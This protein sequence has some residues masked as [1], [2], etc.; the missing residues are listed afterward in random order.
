MRNIKE[1]LSQY[2]NEALIE[3]RALGDQL[4]EEAHQA[5][6]DI[7]NERGQILP[8]RPMAPIMHVKDRKVDRGFFEKTGWLIV[9][10]GVLV[11]SKALAHTWLGIPLSLL[12]L[13]VWGI[14]KIR[15]R[16]FSKEEAKEDKDIEA[17]CQEGLTDLMVASAEGDIQRAE[18]LINYGADVNAKSLSGSTPLMYAARNNNSKIIELLLK[19]GADRGL[20][21]L[22]N[23]TALSIAQNFKQY[24]A[25]A[26]LVERNK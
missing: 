16:T 19:H 9:A 4:S 17:P 10:G 24:D 11:V 2:T 21:N 15:K 3:R 22:N 14:S 13:L 5:I 12:I 18:D 7:F 25:I 1:T 6:E 8:P 23:S 20:A 26:I